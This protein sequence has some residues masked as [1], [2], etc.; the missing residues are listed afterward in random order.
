MRY[1]VCQ[2]LLFRT[3]SRDICAR[4]VYVGQYYTSRMEEMLNDVKKSRNANIEF[5]HFI[6]GKSWFT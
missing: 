6:V 2:K 5:Q 1:V 4:D 3:G